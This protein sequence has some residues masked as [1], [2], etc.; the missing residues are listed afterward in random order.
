[1][2]VSAK[3]SIWEC[4]ARLWMSLSDWRDKSVAVSVTE[5]R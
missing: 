4:A 1:M 5:I 2:Y 3:E